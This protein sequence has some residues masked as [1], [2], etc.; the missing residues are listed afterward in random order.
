MPTPDEVNDKFLKVVN[1]RSGG[2]ILGLAR[3]FKIIDKDNSGQLSPAEFKVAMSKFRVGL[4]ND[5]VK[6]LFD[7]YDRDRSGTLNFDEFLK[8]LRAKLSPQRRALAEQAF[9]VMDSNGSGEIDYEDL[10]EKYDVTNHPKVRSNEWTKKQA[11][12]EFIKN[13]EGDNGDHNATITKMEWLDY[14]AGLS[15]SLDTDD[16]FGILMARNW[17]IEYIPQ[18]NIKRIMQIIRDKAEQ[19]SGTKNAKRVAQDIFKFFDTDGTHSIDYQE[20]IRALESFG[21]GLNEKE[22]HTFFRMFDHDG[23]GEISYD[24]LINLIFDGK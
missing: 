12:D 2:G 6:I 22:T 11:L 19:K 18:E 15:A 21:A 16:E 1:S 14:H 20:F 9:N 24:E 13:F 23:S 17:G 4:N 10:K 8:G 5:E 3:N 7:Y